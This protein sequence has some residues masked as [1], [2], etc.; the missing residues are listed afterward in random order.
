M[1]EVAGS[2]LPLAA[3]CL[4]FFWQI[5]SL[6][7]RRVRHSLTIGEKR[8]EEEEK[9]KRGRV[10]EGPHFQKCKPGDA[11][12]DDCRDDDGNNSKPRSEGKEEVQ[13]DEFIS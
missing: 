5:T 7:T 2:N 13:K 11:K 8:R 10:E 12:R 1:Q 9:R 6:V 3:A 4:Y